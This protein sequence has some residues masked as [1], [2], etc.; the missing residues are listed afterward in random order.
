MSYLH[1]QFWNFF[2]MC[3]M[4]IRQWPKKLEKLEAEFL[5]APVTCQMTASHSQPLQPASQKHAKMWPARQ[6]TD[7]VKIGR[8]MKGWTLCKIKTL[9]WSKPYLHW[10]QDEGWIGGCGFLGNYFSTTE[11]HDVAKIWVHILELS[12]LGCSKRS[13]GPT[14]FTGSATSF[15]KYVG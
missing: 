11:G 5:F 10:P 2:K 13:A 9:I 6:K 12:V 3:E 15:Q 4:S 14:S 1:S 8:H 7:D